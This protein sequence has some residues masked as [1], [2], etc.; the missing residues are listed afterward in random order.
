MK[1]LGVLAFFLAAGVAL[2]NLA[3]KDKNSPYTFP[4]HQMG[5]Y[6]SDPSKA[7]APVTE[8]EEQT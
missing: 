5:P 8:S 7:P 2:P 1:S 6:E 3:L 4:A